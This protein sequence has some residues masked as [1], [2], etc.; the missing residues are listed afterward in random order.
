MRVTMR[1]SILFCYAALLHANPHELRAFRA[2]CITR[3]MGA[4][5]C[6]MRLIGHEAHE[7]IADKN[8]RM[9]RALKRKTR[10]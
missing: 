5:L 9:R 1:C 4:I 10:A 3:N 8:R 6:V 7:I 2:S